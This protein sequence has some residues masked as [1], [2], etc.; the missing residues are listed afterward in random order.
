[1]GDQKSEKIVVGRFGAPHG[2]RGGLK[3]QSFT[4]QA[5]DIFSY[6]PL[7]VAKGSSWQPVEV[8][9]SKF[10]GKHF[11]TT[12]KG[13]DDRD[14]ASLLTNCEV[15]VQRDAMPA[16]ADGDVYWNDLIG[17]SVL[18]V[19]GGQ[20][21]KIGI[22]DHILETGANDVLVVKP[23]SDSIDSSERLVPYIDSVVI[24][25]DL[26]VSQLTVDWDPEF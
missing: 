18:S 21:T 1:M 2:V 20:E 3:L 6:G 13:I 14:T 24:D 15:A 16:A 4:E 22:I 5:E 12:V 25:V 8:T 9:S 11:L 23:S 17:L 7:F 26:S 19:Y 10:Q